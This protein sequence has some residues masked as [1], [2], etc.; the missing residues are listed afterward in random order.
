MSRTKRVL[1][2]PFKDGVHGEWKVFIVRKVDKDDSDAE[3]RTESREILVAAKCLRDP[4]LLGRT[5][6][7]ELQHAASGDIPYP[8]TSSLYKLLFWSEEHHVER[9]SGALFDILTDLNWKL[10]PVPPEAEALLK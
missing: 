7:H 8:E 6:L 3:T 2:F 10:P 1:W 4:V 5:V 9:S